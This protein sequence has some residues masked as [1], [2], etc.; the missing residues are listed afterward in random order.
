MTSQQS[1]DLMLQQW[2]ALRALPPEERIEKLFTDFFAPPPPSD[3]LYEITLRDVT[4]AM[5]NG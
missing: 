5:A 2:Q 3:L 4:E 1:A